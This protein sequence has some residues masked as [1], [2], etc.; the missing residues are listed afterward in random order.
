METSFLLRSQ[1]YRK[2]I[3]VLLVTLLFS[4]YLYGVRQQFLYVNINRFKIDQNAYLEAAKLLKN[5]NYT[6][7]TDRNRMPL[8]PF[9]L[10]LAYEPD[11]T[12]EAFF[13]RGKLFN[14][15]LSLLILPT[16]FWLFRRYLPLGTAVTLIL[17]HIFTL[18]IF[19]AAYAQPELLFYL[20]SFIGF[21]LMGHLLHKPTGQKTW[22]TAVLTGILLGLTHLTKA[23][24]LPGLGIFIGTALLQAVIRLAKDHV[25][26]IFN[27]Q[28]LQY[29]ATP[30][31]VLLF[32]LLTIWPYIQNSKERFGQYFYNVNSTFYIWYDS[33]DDVLAGTRAHGDR[34]GWPD[35]PPE[36]IPSAGKY[37]QEHSI[38]EVGQR[39]AKGLLTVLVGMA[40]SYGYLKYLILLFG[41]VLGLFLFNRQ[42]IKTILK[43]FPFLVLFSTGFFIVYVLLYAWYTPIANGNRLVLALFSPLTFTFTFIIY[44]LFDKQLVIKLSNNSK[45]T[46]H[47]GNLL[48]WTLGFILL[49]DGYIILTERISSMYGG[50]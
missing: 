16:L 49:I 2:L 3:I 33:W 10:S 22:G 32:F 37:F 42:R 24:I 7:L 25:R 48:N 47:L 14:I 21:L 39:I 20:L 31:L 11:L 29:F 44:R 36:E 28:N 19:K 45:R 4:L 40:T 8:Y 9:L 23:S 41:L 1:P 43:E 5:S 13:A 12:D 6:D 26:P 30:T 15:G 18:Y 46:V 27:R 38:A 34:V 35:L 17:I 50:F